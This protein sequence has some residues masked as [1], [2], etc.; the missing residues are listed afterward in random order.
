[1]QS[2]QTNPFA[3]MIEPTQV[4]EAIERAERL[5]RLQRRVC[6]PLDAPV[7]VARSADVIAFDARIDRERGRPRQNPIQPSA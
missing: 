5:Q 6:K 1:M 4:F 7:M 2:T 3:L